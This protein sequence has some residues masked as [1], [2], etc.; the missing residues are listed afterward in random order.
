MPTLPRPN[1]DRRRSKDDGTNLTEGPYLA[2]TA[3]AY[4]NTYFLSTGETCVCDRWMRLEFC[5][6]RTS[7]QPGSCPSATLDERYK[8]P[9]DPSRFWIPWTLIIIFFPTL[10]LQHHHHRRQNQYQQRHRHRRQQLPLTRSPPLLRIL[11]Q[12][13]LYLSRCRNTKHRESS[14]SRGISSASFGAI[15]PRNG[16]RRRCVTFLSIQHLSSSIR[17]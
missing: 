16:T 10:P 3:G 15:R 6:R 9:T 7:Q 4:R 1:H 2:L 13:C 8:V 17:R 11:Q 12:L 5:S 14:L